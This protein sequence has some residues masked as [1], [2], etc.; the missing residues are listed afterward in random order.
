MQ[1]ERDLLLEL[2]AAHIANEEEWCST[3]CRLFLMVPVLMS[4][5]R[6]HTGEA[7][8]AMRTIQV[9]LLGQG[10][11]V[12]QMMLQRSQPFVLHVTMVAL[13]HHRRPI[14]LRLVP[15]AAVHQCSRFVEKLAIAAHQEAA[16]SVHQPVMLAYRRKRFTL[17]SAH[18]ALHRYVA[19]Q[20]LAVAD[21][22]GGGFVDRRLSIHRMGCRGRGMQLVCSLDRWTELCGRLVGQSWLLAGCLLVTLFWQSYEDWPGV[23]LFHQQRSSHIIRCVMPHGQR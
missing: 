11:A 3:V 9:Q 17:N 1:I 12:A 4:A 14:G 20:Q 18:I 6:H 15:L 8:V 7:L 5:Q 2:F 21:R 23:C 19:A 13:E 10:M 16:L 22:S